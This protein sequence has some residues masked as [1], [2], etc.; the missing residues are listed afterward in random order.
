[1][2]V[3]V[4]A[5][6][7]RI[8]VVAI[9]LVTIGRPFINSIR[10]GR[11]A[12]RASPSE[13]S[14]GPFNLAYRRSEQRRGRLQN[15]AKVVGHGRP[16]APRSPAHDPAPEAE[17]DSGDS[18]KA[19][20]NIAILADAYDDIRASP[21]W[22]DSSPSPTSFVTTKLATLFGACSSVAIS[23]YS[24]VASRKRRACNRSNELVVRPG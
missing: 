2:S 7:L 17:A 6:Q 21:M 16:L 9:A 13:T 10:D 14:A 5:F 22:P 11:A 23:I 8:I 3:S 20:S 18:D 4:S 1:M 19:L 24:L 15:I 12:D